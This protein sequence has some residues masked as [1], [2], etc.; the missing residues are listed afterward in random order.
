MSDALKEFA[1]VSNVHIDQA[2]TDFSLK[3]TNEEMIAGRV[4]PK[5]KVN[6]RS[7]RFFKYNKENA[8]RIY[9]DAVGPKSMPNEVTLGVSNDNYSVDDHALAD[10]V[11]VETQD[12]ADQ[13][14]EPRMDTVMFL[15][16]QLALAWE[17]RVADVV[18]AAGTYPTGNKKTLTGNAQW[19]GSADDPL[20]DILDAIE[21]SFMRANCLIFGQETWQKFRT[22]PEILD[23]VK[24]STRSQ[25]ADGG[26]ANRQEIASLFEVD[27]VLVGRARHI[28]SNEGQSNTYGRVWGKHFA[29]LYV[30]PSPGIKTLT[31]GGTFTEQDTLVQSAMDMKRGVKGAEYIKVGW[32]SDEKVIANDLGY[33]ITNAVA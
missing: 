33:L 18:F 21:I 8:Y 16:D 23:A 6:K 5:I 1:E 19:G 3:Y 24:S 15:Q 31:F 27:H 14:I 32:N 28:T 9:D 10:Y 30:H 12:N 2:L 13:P 20:D 26:I 4:M 22:L 7:N 25:S 29:A 17:K 11:P